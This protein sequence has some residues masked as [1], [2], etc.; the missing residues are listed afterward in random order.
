M[1]G[2]NSSES[3]SLGSRAR[4]ASRRVTGPLAS[5]A[6]AITGKGVEQRVAEYTETFTQVVQ[7]LHE[8]LATASRRIG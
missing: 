6:V 5:A 2:R 3:S 4:E 8:D 1:E 7:G